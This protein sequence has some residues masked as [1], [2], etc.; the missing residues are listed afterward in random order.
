MLVGSVPFLVVSDEVRQHSD[1][2][3]VSRA[4]CIIQVIFA[5]VNEAMPSRSRRGE[6][7]P[8]PGEKSRET[9][10]R[11]KLIQC[12]VDKYEKL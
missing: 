3:C 8:P 5:L 1:I 7:P 10:D 6:S 9:K 12:K 4:T 2:Y 11:A